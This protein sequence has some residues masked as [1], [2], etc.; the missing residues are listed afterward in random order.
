[1]IGLLALLVSKLFPKNNKNRDQFVIFGQTSVKSDL[2]CWSLKITTSY[3]CVAWICY[4]VQT[5][6]YQDEC[7]VFCGKYWYIRM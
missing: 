5:S 2:H 4:S 1:M 7:C 3:L 6:R